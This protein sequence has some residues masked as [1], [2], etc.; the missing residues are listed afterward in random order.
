VV[1]VKRVSAMQTGE[2]ATNPQ[3]SESSGAALVAR[4]KAEMDV[5]VLEPDRRDVELLSIAEALPDRIAEL[6]SVIAAEEMT[7][8]PSLLWRI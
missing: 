3:V 7:R 6:E 2:K 8:S 5:E 1:L 4:L